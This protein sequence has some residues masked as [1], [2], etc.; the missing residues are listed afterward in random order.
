VTRSYAP[1]VA[2]IA[3]AQP[4]SPRRGRLISSLGVLVVYLA[5]AVALFAS[6]W[7]NPTYLSVGTAGDPELF[8]WLLAWVPYSISHGLNPLFTN[9]LIYPE[10]ANLMWTLIPIVPGLV[11]TPVMALLGPVLAYNALM[12]L[13]LGTSAW[14]AYLAIEALVGDRIAAAIGGFIFGFSPYMLSHSLG[15]PNLVI[16]VT[17]PLVLLILAEL[18]VWQRRP[19]RQSGL[20]LGLLAA[21]QLLTTPEILFTTAFVGA[22]G[23]VVL[24]A[25]RPRAVAGHF[26]HALTG[27]VVATAVFIPIAALPMAFLFFGPQHVSGVVRQQDIFVTDLLNVVV[28]TRVML[29]A[30][31]ALVSLSHAWTGGEAEANAYIGVPLIA[32]LAF[33][34]LR[35]RSVP[36]VLWSALLAA[37]VAVLSLGPHLHLG[38]SIHFHFPLPWLLLQPLPLFDNVLP[39]RLMFFFYLLAAVAAAF[40]VGELR[41]HVTGWK[42]RAGWLWIGVCLLTL[43]PLVPWPATPNPV[44]EFFS[45]GGVTR[46][47]AGSVALVAPFSTAPGFQ[48]GP[49]QDSATYPML[50]QV[51][52]GMRYRMPEGSLIVPDVNGSPSGGRPPAS[53]TQSTMIAIQQ[54][55]S[56]PDLTPSL[57]A[58]V[59]ADLA[60][61]Q[62][63]TVIV[64]PMY[65][66]AAMVAFVNSL[67]GREPQSVGG[68]LV[69][70]DVTF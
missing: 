26:R 19:A 11:L 14:C 6:A 3:T 61:W 5:L 59:T 68:V 49:G 8:M 32:L 65:N 47:P 9:F 42:V 45:G 34:A 41:Q 43:L 29:L 66:Q 40:F 46:V 62:V 17:P 39:A 28:P 52:S 23:A 67:V 58:A 35:W 51:A 30:P 48:L 70:W 57:K 20:A 33:V 12:T 1:P 13:A 50:W 53:T 60:R 25:I 24:V 27:L 7:A 69:W 54:G 2:S 38:G 15:H 16:C 18:F 56:A 10:G 55:G 37:V 44:P 22:L 64:G 31:S 36:L 4:P 63:H 21:A